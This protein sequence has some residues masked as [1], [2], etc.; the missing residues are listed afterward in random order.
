MQVSVLHGSTRTGARIIHYTVRGPGVAP[1][2]AARGLQRLRQRGHGLDGSGG[3]RPV[4]P[5][6]VGLGEGPARATSAA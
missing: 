5:D 4:R 2:D 6:S 1:I 3:R